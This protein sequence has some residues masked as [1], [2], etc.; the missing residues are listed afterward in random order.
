MATEQLGLTAQ[1]A[2]SG[3]QAQREK[4]LGSE[5]TFVPLHPG[6]PRGPGG[7]SCPGIPCN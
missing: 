4:G 5:F 3:E 7:P 2:K 6:I 1:D